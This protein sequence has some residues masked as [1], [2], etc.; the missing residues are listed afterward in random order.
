MSVSSQQQQPTHAQP[1]FRTAIASTSTIQEAL[2]HPTGQEAKTQINAISHV[3]PTHPHTAAA[4]A[5]Q[6]LQEVANRHSPTLA[7]NSSDKVSLASA[8]EAL[9]EQLHASEE[10]P[11]FFVADNGVYSEANISRFNKAKV[12]WISR[13]PETSKEVREMVETAVES[14]DWQDTADGQ[15]H[16][17]TRTLSLTQGEERWV[18]VRT[19]QGEARAQA[20]LK[21]QVEKAEHNWKQKLWHLTNQRFACE[22]D[23]QSAV[24]RERKGLPVWLDVQSEFVRV[25]HHI[26]KGR[27]KKEA[28]LTLQW[29]ITSTV[30]VNQPR[31]E[32][33]ARRK[34][35]FIVATN[36]LDAAALS[37][38]EV[39][40]IYK[41]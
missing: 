23:A 15:A 19:E 37:E 40:G 16:W 25:P 32:Q 4:A 35:C 2:H 8:V 36:V 21:R 27:P 5:P 28:T 22:V 7:S 30:S 18:I 29:Q 12:R 9:H 14:T 11:G 41:E 6:A 10:D 33:E 34:A 20:T 17:W 31:V 13:V 39:V 1:R 24:T 3:F 26:G 38:Q